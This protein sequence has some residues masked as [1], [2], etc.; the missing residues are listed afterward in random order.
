MLELFDINKNQYIQDANFWE[1]VDKYD[2]DTFNGISFVSNLQ[3]VEKYLLPRF[4]QINLILGLSDNGKNPIGQFLQGILEQRADYANKI[5]LSDQLKKRVLNGTLTFKFTKKADNLIHSKFYLLENNDYYSCF[6]G[7]MNLTSTAV[8]KNHEMLTYFH[9][10][11]TDDLYKMFEKSWIN[12]WRGA[13]EYLDAKHLSGILTGK[14]TAK[15]IAVNMYHDSTDMLSNAEKA[16]KSIYIV[17]KDEIK[18]FAKQNTQNFDDLDMP[19]KITVMQT[20]K[21]FGDSGALRQQ[22]TLHDVPTQLIQVKQQLQYATEKDNAKKEVL[23]DIDLYPKPILTYNSDLDQLYSA[24]KLGDNVH[25]SEFTAD[26]PTIS[27]VKLFIDI[28]NE[29]QSSKLRGE[30]LPAFTFLLYLFESPW[31]WKIRQIYGL[32]GTVKRPEDVPIGTVLIGAGKTGKSTLGNN[33][34][35]KL[36]GII[37]PIEVGDDN[38]NNGIAYFGNDSM[39]NK[40]V[41]KFVNNYM[42]TNGPVSPIL[43]DDIRTDYFTRPYF[44]AM[45]KS[46][47]NRRTE[48]AVMPVMIYTTNLND[49]K[50]D[51]YIS[52][53]AEV[54]RRLLYLGF[55]SPFKADQDHYINAILAKANNHLFNYVQLKLIDFFKNISDETA[56]RIE[57]DYLYPIKAVLTV[58]FK[59][60]NLYSDI[61]SYFEATYDYNITRGKADWRNLVESATYR[62][63]INF[64]DN[65]R[66]ANFPKE[67]FKQISD[68]SRDSNGSSVMKRYFRNLPRKYEISSLLTESGFDVNV[69]NFDKYM[70]FPVLKSLYEDKA[71]ITAAKIKDVERRKDQ[72]MQARI[73]AD[74]LI[75]HDEK[76]KHRLFS[77]F[78]H[79]K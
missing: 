41:Q 78:H 33:L 30:G 42:R 12:N 2:F 76:K 74:A 18:Q 15:Q 23:S 70:G 75:R 26:K 32:L 50:S 9:N 69:E 46:L 22:K 79:D 3:F 31:I 64:V 14:L 65:G 59:E 19:T 73:I 72:E 35:S 38:N 47:A 10:L 4:K 21:I 77:W 55:E 25:L 24:P 48:N 29:Y 1:T 16:D 71:G 56:H 62:K 28:V 54:T 17:N 39:Q 52:N 13:S 68:N 40:N 43:L 6:I 57:R 36:T 61:Q 44:I 51:T 63:L 11:T 67:I 7:S 5:N 45:I 34:A 66:I 20:A 60:Y 49:E 58:I 37:N 53:A 27:D 8:N